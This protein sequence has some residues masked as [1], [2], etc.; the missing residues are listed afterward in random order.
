MKLLI[1][2]LE[3]VGVLLALGIW[4]IIPTVLWDY[5]YSFLAMVAFL[6]IPFALFSLV[7][8]YY[9]WRT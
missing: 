8:Q 1:S 3:S 7:H 9:E 6:A 4:G 5:G 2:F